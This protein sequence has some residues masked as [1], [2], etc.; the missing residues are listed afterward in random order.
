MPPLCQSRGRFLIAAA[1]P[2]AASIPRALAAQSGPGVR[3]AATANDTYAEAYYADAL[4]SF[5]KAGLDVEIQTFTAGG[6]VTA[7]VAGGS[8]DIGIAGAPTIAAASLHGI[9]F[10][11]L[12]AGGIYTS[13]H[14]TTG[15]VVATD[16]PIKTAR[17]FEGQSIAVGAIKDGNW[18]AAVAWID[19]H[20][21]D[22][23]KVK[24]VELPF[25]EM[26][27]AIKRGTIAGGTLPEPSQ[28]RAMKTGG[29][30][31]F[32]HHFDAYGKRT[33]IGGWFAR[34]E[35]IA[36]NAATARRYAGVIYQTARW[37]NARPAESAPILANVSKID[38]ETMRTMIRCHY[39]E[40]LTP[41]LVQSQLDL[42]V[43]YG[44]LDRAVAARDILATT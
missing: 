35:W 38:D 25:A 3:V 5:K 2:L 28:T 4:G 27:P 17:D 29:L 19:T 15:I 40:S 34:A 36:A 37:A 12:A 30:R 41:A 21:G 20:G 43:K 7:A 11:F 9:P 26:G 42:S 44:V 22:A 18:L 8:A 16:G 6:P 10:Q 33:L 32:A 23:S 14:P 31:M 39:G 1:V 13:D 24:F